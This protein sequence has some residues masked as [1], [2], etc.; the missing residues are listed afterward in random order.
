MIS[1]VL[2][3][4]LL[5]H[6][7]SI[8]R[9]RAL[10]ERVAPTDLPVLIEGPTGSG[11]ELV[12]QA[13]HLASTR[14]GSF[15]AFNVCAIAEGMFEDALFGH[16]RGAFTGAIQNSPGLLR[17]ADRGTLFLD[18]I[19]G[20]ALSGQA[21]LL[22]AL[23]TK[24]F[25]PVGGISDVR[26]DFRLVA[27]S[28]QNLWT[29]VRSGGFR[30]DLAHR[31][32]VF[33]IRV[34]ALQARPEDIMPLA[35]HFI[36]THTSEPN[37]ELAAEAASILNSHEWP[38]NVRELKHVVQ[39]A[40]VLSDGRIIRKEDVLQALSWSDGGGVARQ[41]GTSEQQLLSVLERCTWNVRTAA[42][43]LGVH[44]TTLY[45]RLRRLGLD[46]HLE[47]RTSSLQAQ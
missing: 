25:R 16:L 39:S 18:E 21:K 36:R 29:L 2:C 42:T 38:G 40:A 15:V 9:V 33:V 13:L 19:G 31:L 44:H 34:D 1:D 45:R 46:A 35:R 5:G 4:L 32:T 14:S 3:K 37:L 23:E 12:A 8:R 28:N 41:R 27:A 43:E 47:A 30:N 7:L 20:L 26:S 17:E 22:R 11:K 6:S 10:I 24:E